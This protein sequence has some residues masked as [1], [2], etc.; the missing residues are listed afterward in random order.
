MNELTDKTDQLSDSF[1]VIN[2][3]I[4]MWMNVWI[5]QTNVI[6]VPS[7]K[8]LMVHTLVSVKSVIVWMDTFVQVSN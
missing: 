2:Y 7:V 5:K 4:Q 6:G 1:F 3:L 8:T